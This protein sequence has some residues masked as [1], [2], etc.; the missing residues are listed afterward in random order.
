MR[1]QQRFMDKAASAAVSR[2][3]GE[4][5][6]LYAALGWKVVPKFHALSHIAYDN[7]G[8]NPR[9]VHCYQ[10]EDMVG[11]LKRIYLRCHGALA[12]FVS[13]AGL[14]DIHCVGFCVGHE[15]SARVLRQ[16]RLAAV[17]SATGS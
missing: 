12:S 10:D 7:G 14:F 17:C 9:Q 2:C 15:C 16:A 3:F 11:K 6:E 5:L 13:G 1:S 4:A 8:V